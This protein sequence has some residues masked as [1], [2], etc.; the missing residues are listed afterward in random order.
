MKKLCK[1]LKLEVLY[2]QI[3]LMKKG[4]VGK[5]I[6]QIIGDNLVKYD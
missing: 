5:T 2:Q 4:V 1:G 6:K 3:N